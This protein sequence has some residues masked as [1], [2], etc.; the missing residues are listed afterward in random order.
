MKLNLNQFVNQSQMQVLRD[1]CKGEEK[2]HFISIIEKL[3]NTIAC[4][5]ATYDTDGQSDDALVSLHYFTGSSHWWIIERDCEQ[6]QL[7]ALGFVGLNGWVDD[8]ELGYVS[9]SE[10]IRNGAELDLYWKPTT[11]AEVRESLRRK[12]V[13]SRLDDW[14]NH[15]GGQKSGN[16]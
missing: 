2:E 12:A 3:K 16:H 1:L 8:A 14:L 7:Q 10:L 15:V 6:E 9:I 5:P 4:M 11:L 13:Q